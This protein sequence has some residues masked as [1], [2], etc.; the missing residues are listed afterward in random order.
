MTHA[1]KRSKW[2]LY[3]HTNNFDLITAV[4]VNLKFYSK[5]SISPESKK[6]QLL[7]LKN[8]GHYKE[9][10]LELPLDSINHRINTLEYYMFGYKSNVDGNDKFM[11]NPLGNLFLKNIKNKD[12]ISKIFFSMLWGAQFPNSFG[13]DSIFQ[14]YPFR[15]IFKLLHD[16]RLENKLYAFEMAYHVVF[17][18]SIDEEKYEELIKKILE[19]RK[20]SNKEI[21]KI[22]KDE[23][24]VLVNATYEWD[25]YVSNFL[26]FAGVLDKEEGE[27]ICTLNQGESTIRKLTRNSVKLNKNM[28]SLYAKLEEGYPFTEKPLLLDDPERLT[29]DVTKEIHSFFPEELLEEIGEKKDKIKLELLNLSKL[30]EKYAE[31]DSG[32]EWDLFENILVDGF[33]SFHN[34]EARAIGG[35]SQTDV[36]CLYITKK[37]KFAVDGKS[38]KNKLSNLNA[39]R[40][41][42]HREKIGAEYTIVVTPRYVP[43]VLV[44]IKGSSNVIIRAS[45]FSEYLYNHF[46]NDVREI[47]Y[48]DFDE[49]II[50]NLGSDISNKISDLT[51]EKFASRTK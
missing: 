37:K 36:E 14:I 35:A 45:T 21:E 48:M 7:E 18:D 1:I 44:D 24:H 26:T 41:A 39:G 31:N 30:I 20:L 5:T 23:E 12:N 34:V 25:Y 4:A 38:T 10:N 33:N 6:E 43:S 15:L 13:S 50:N 17:V 11:F 8:L 51:L 28:E 16:E 42:Y 2:I 9:R 49:T 22:F 47:D 46:D 3:R 29:I 40:L 32:R 19:I 27:V